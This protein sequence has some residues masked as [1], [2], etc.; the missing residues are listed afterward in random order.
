MNQILRRI[1]GLSAVLALAGCYAIVVPAVAD[2]RPGDAYIRL[3]N[4]WPDGGTTTI[5]IDGMAQTPQLSFAQASRYRALP[6][7][8]HTVTFAPHHASISTTLLV[9]V[10]VTP[11]SYST[12]IALGRAD[13][14]AATVTDERFSAAGTGQAGVRFVNLAGDVPAAQLSAEGG[15]VVAGKTTFPSASGYVSVP[16][17]TY[18]FGVQAS[19]DTG[20]IA[21]LPD[22]T[23]TAG[24]TYSVALV[25]GSDQPVVLTRLLDAVGLAVVPLGP[26][27]TG[28]G[29]SSDDRLP[30]GQGR[31][32]SPKPTNPPS[33]SQ[34]PVAI[35]IPSQHEGG[36]VV[37][38]DL[39]PTGALQVLS[40]ARQVGW[41]RGS[42]A[43]G[44]PGPAVLIGHI[45]LNGVEGVFK[46]LQDLSPGAPV[47]IRRKDGSS[48]TFA[49]DRIEIYDK[50][51]FPTS[52]AYAP[53]PLP[54][55]ILASCTGPL[56]DHHYT[57]NVVV[58]ASSP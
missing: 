21:S 32:T 48:V 8:T 20:V 33:T 47:I 28:P 51:T 46:D 19:P 7:G 53:T 22:T 15:P 13:G 43:P 10:T 27:P 34:P 11:N 25:G 30:A 24:N 12:V 37:P 6:A 26:V 55:L 58:Y 4:A 35:S 56:I 3:L 36:P 42:P 49:V 5:A 2:T 29:D 38:I 54:E 45:N 18:T 44:D 23:L 14:P 41:Y 31:R 39:D 40:S 1:L 16:A 50:N 17:G 52:L 57:Q 9:P